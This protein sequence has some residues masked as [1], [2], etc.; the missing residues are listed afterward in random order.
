M[1]RRDP[2]CLT[3]LT[4]S[5]NF[6]KAIVS[7]SRHHWKMRNKRRIQFF[8]Q[9]IGKATKSHVASP[10]RNPRK[11]FRHKTADVNRATLP[12]YVPDR[13]RA[14]PAGYKIWIKLFVNWAQPFPTTR[15]N[16]FGREQERGCKKHSWRAREE[17]YPEGTVA[18][19]FE[20]RSV[21]SRMLSPE[22][23]IER[24]KRKLSA[25]TR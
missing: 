3:R 21:I 19:S 5:A 11:P 1:T 7:V 2:W 23:R 16:T 13:T 18:V 10:G 20:Q 6:R 15:L 9:A 4:S 17:K 14:L 25:Q 12:I 24:E 22:A 8:P